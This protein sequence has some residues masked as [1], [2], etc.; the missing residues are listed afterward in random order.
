M[1]IL[2]C[3]YMCVHS[4]HDLSTCN[5]F[6]NSMRCTSVVANKTSNS[7]ATR[8][9]PWAADP[10][11]CQFPPHLAVAV[12]ATSP[13]AL[14]QLGIRASVMAG[15]GT[16]L[17]PIW[18]LSLLGDTWAWLA[19]K[20]FWYGERKL[21]CE[22]SA[23]ARPYPFPPLSF[24]FITHHLSMLPGEMNAQTQLKPIMNP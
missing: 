3:I 18:P 22:P 21:S 23:Q 4:A 17:G 24:C 5:L 20:H 2:F 12:A 19:A 1:N 16:V 6:R 7:K 14:L 11:P 15:A 8:K 13:F 9:L 10:P